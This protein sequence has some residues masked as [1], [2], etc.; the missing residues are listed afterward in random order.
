[1]VAELAVAKE[2][3]FKGW[4]N[5]TFVNGES[6]E[7]VVNLNGSAVIILCYIS[8]MDWQGSGVDVVDWDVWGKVDVS[9]L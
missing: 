5:F 2:S 9:V 6:C 1:M 4:H 3:V 8:Y 7:K